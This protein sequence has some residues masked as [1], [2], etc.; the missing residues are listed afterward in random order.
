M[1]TGDDRHQEG[2]GGMGAEMMTRPYTSDLLPSIASGHS[3]RHTGNVAVPDMKDYPRE[4]T[5]RKDLSLS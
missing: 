5:C 3:G 4:A 2:I 1:T